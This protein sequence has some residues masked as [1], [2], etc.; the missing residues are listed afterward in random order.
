M[1]YV[2][3]LTG[4]IGAGKTAVADRFAGVGVD[5]IDTDV[6]AHALTAPGGIAM[7][8]IRK[9][10]GDPFVA[11]DG[12]LERDRMRDLVFSD[13]DS[14]LALQ[15]ILHPRIR[16]QVEA[17]VEGSTAAYAMVVVPLLVESRSYRN[18]GWRIAVVDCREQTQIARVMARSRM[19]RQE[20]LRIMASQ[21]SRAERLE[22]ADDVIDNDG[23]VERLAA[24]IDRLHAIYLGGAAAS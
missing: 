14:R 2:V 22:T 10:F 20:V 17:R 7:D 16:A 6:I 23:P 9:R 19:T 4:G 21:V 15:E 1:T 5:I 11:A 24:Q 13:P 18:R 8:D 12:S 3:G